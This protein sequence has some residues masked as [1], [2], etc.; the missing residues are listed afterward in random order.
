[1][2]RDEKFIVSWSKQ[3]PIGLARF[4]QIYGVMGWGS[5]CALIMIMI[6]S[7]LRDDPLAWFILLIAI[8]FLLGGIFF[9]FF[10]FTVNESRY[11]KLTKGLPEQS[12]ASDVQKA[13]PEE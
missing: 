7:F 13:A 10:L 1:M 3:R 2:N 12:F 4:I 11:R 5:N 8:L 9:G 6:F